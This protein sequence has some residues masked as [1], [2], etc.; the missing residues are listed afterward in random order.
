MAPAMRRPRNPAPITATVVP[1]E[2]APVMAGA[3]VAVADPADYPGGT[4]TDA[5]EAR[6]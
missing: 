6:G 3:K 1:I 5:G 2:F 4:R